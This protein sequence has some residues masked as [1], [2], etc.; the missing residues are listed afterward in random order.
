MPAA[1]APQASGCARTLINQRVL[2]RE[3]LAFGSDCDHLRLS[4]AMEPALTGGITYPSRPANMP[5]WSPPSRAGRPEA[6]GV[7]TDQLHVSAM[8]PPFTSGMAV[9]LAP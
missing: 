1:L 4:T 8:E 5:Q 7:L 3:L 9:T 2:F 6:V